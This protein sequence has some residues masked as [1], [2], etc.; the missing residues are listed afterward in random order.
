MDHIQVR[1]WFTALTRF[2]GRPLCQYT[3]TGAGFILRGRKRFTNISIKRAVFGKLGNTGLKPIFICG[4][5][6]PT[7][8]DYASFC[9]NQSK[10]V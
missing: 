5:L 4:M 3:G 2:A 10:C 9:R 6:P 1:I 7:K 8:A